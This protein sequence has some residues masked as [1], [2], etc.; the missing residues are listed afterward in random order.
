MTTEVAPLV[1]KQARSVQLATAAVNVWEGSVRSSKT[2]CSLLAWL[3]FLRQGPAGNTVMIGKTE[4][5]LRRNVIDPLIEMLGK[6]RCKVN[7]GDGEA[8]ILGRRVYLAGA[9]NEAAVG[10]IQGITLAGAYVDEAPLMPEPMWAMLRSRLSV[11]G[12]QLFA[13]GNPDA[14]QHWLM[15]DHL[16]RARLWLR[17][18][19]TVEE[20][21]DPSALDLA[22]FSF[23]L[24]DNPSLPAGYVTELSKT[25]VGLW[26]KRYI[27]GLWVLA[28]GAIYDMWDEATHVHDDLPRDARGHVRL[29]DWTLAIDYG[30]ANPFAA[31]LLAVDPAEQRLWIAR[32]WRWDSRKQG[33]QLTDPDYSA[34]LRTWI[35]HTLPTELGQPITIDHIHV[36]PSAAS[37]IA[38]LWRDQWPGVRGADNTVADGIRSVSSLLADGRLQVHRS[39]T[40]WTTEIGSYVWDD[41]RWTGEERPTKVDDHSMDAGRYGVMGMR[42]HWRWWLN[43]DPALHAAA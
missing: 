35:D 14:P 43:V 26:R 33:R 4:R 36:D 16:S 38:Q 39:C 21:D 25:F 42:R 41:H 32:E 13:T 31:L 24:A 10:K 8:L 30:T 40:G 28:E 6:R 20:S 34:K 9:N 5:T 1:G 22:R 11:E 2:V 19:G 29:T 12:A 7:W 18:D 17:H 3:R 37:F 15:R 23:R 27:D